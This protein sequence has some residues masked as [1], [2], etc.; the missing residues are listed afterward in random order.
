MEQRAC[1]G[2]GVYGLRP[3]CVIVLAH[4]H[5]DLFLCLQLFKSHVKSLM[6][7][8]YAE[9]MYLLVEHRFRNFTN[10]EDDE[11]AILQLNKCLA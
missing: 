5:T 1:E 9:Q 10:G 7:C 6:G 11:L 4:L 2:L 8:L 3:G